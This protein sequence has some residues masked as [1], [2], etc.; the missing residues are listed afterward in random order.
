DFEAE[1]TN[2][3]MMFGDSTIEARIDGQTHRI[4]VNGHIE[5]TAPAFTAKLD[6]STLELLEATATAASEGEVLSLEP[7]ATMRTLLTGVSKSMPHIP[8]MVE[9]GTFVTHPGY[10]E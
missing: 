10:E 9:G 2:A 6:A 5:Y 8:V 4:E 3:F 1:K 7:A